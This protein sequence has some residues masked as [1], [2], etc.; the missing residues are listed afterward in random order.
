MDFRL[1]KV[2]KKVKRKQC[3]YGC[4]L[5]NES[6]NTLIRLLDKIIEYDN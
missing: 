3:M 5:K 2:T 4:K 6:I 1:R